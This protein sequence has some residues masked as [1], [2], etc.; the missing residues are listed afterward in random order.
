MLKNTVIRRSLAG[1]FLLLCALPVVLAMGY[2]AL[3]SVGLTGLQSDGF[4]LQHWATLFQGEFLSSFLYSLWIAGA[5]SALALATA[6]AALF[7]L[8]KELT[9]K[10]VYRML[11]LPLTVPPVVIGFVIYQL[12]SGGGILS[13]VSYQSG[14][15]DQ[16]SHFPE[17]VHDAYGVGIILAHLFIGFPFFLILLLNLY[18]QNNLDE[19]EITAAS[20]GAGR[21][22][23]LLRVHLPVLL[24]GIFPVVSLYTIFF[25][26]AYEIP[27]ILGQSSPQ[28]F[29]ILILEKLQRYSLSDIPVAYAM[30]LFYAIICIGTLSWLMMQY[31]KRWN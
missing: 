29:T 11:F 18:Q 22:D 27:L 28:M 14:L 3:Y 30:A 23:I 20:L 26:G 12:F 15:I 31:K 24:K 5:S 7:T 10:R 6:L 2:A 4:M 21:K 9:D 1:L 16:I 25:M 17:F 13:R 19:L 8:R